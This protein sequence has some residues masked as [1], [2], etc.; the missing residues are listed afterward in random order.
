MKNFS[1]VSVKQ[2]VPPPIEIKIFP[3]PAAQSATISVDTENRNYML[4]VFDLQGRVINETRNI[5]QRTY[6]LDLHGIKAGIYL[7]RLQSDTI[8]GV[9]KLVVNE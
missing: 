2:L 4:T 5:Q 6:D 8:S 1:K 7:L 3:N 9:V